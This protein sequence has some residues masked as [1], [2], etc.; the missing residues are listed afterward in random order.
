MNR[1]PELTASIEAYERLMKTAADIHIDP[2][3]VMLKIINQLV[4]A[5]VSAGASPDEVLS[6]V[7]KGIEVGKQK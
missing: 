3:K 7:R 4:L 1:S 5:L 2:A 6:V